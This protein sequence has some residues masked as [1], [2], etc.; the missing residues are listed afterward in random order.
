MNFVFFRLMV[1]LKFSHAL[2]NRSR[3]FWSFSS[4]R[5]TRAVSSAKTKSRRITLRPLV[6]IRRRAG[7]KSFPSDRVRNRM[8]SSADLNACFRRTEKKM[9]KSVGASTQ[10]FFTPLFMQNA[11]VMLPLY[12]TVPRVPSRNDLMELRSFRR[13]LINGRILKSPA[14]LTKSKAFVRSINAMKRDCCCSR[15][16]SWSCLSEKIISTLERLERKPQ[17]YS[18]YTLSASGCRRCSAYSGKQLSSNA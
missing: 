11:S 16:F 7:L 12:W 13:Q 3:R 1:R 4:L 14:L 18:G 6:F 10:P 17:W 8:P 2:E 15:H 5:A 9:L